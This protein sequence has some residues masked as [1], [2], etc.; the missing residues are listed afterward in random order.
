MS[1]SISKYRLLRRR[2]RVQL[3]I[4]RSREHRQLL[5]A[6]YLNCLDGVVVDGTDGAG[7]EEV[8]R[9][10]LSHQHSLVRAFDFLL[11][12]RCRG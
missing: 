10:P 9:R 1:R 2:V 5:L 4:T 7:A 12:A 3:P 11:L 6:I 8:R